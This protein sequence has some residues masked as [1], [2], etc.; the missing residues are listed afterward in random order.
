MRLAELHPRSAILEAWVRV[1][2]AART[3]LACK[4][5][6]VTS[7]GY[8]PASRL[9]EPLTKKGVIEPENLGL[10]HDLRRLR[11]EVAHAQGFEPTLASANQ[12]IDLASSLLETIEKKQK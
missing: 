7:P 3:A 11:N 1:E 10:F 2:A 12:Y 5:T 6:S 9:G 8:I 4:S